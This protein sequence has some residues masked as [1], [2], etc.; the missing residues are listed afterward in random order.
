MSEPADDVEELTA[1]VLSAEPTESE[2][3]ARAFGLGS[4]IGLVL[5]ALGRRR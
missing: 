3:I 4:L 5:A 2:R 1:Q